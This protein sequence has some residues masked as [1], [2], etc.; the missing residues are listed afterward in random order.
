[1]I[2]LIQVGTKTR[3][4]TFLKH[5]E[6]VVSVS[7]K[8]TYSDVER[9]FGGMYEGFEVKI[10]RIKEIDL[11]PE[12]QKLPPPSAD[13]DEQRPISRLRNFNI[14]LTDTEKQTLETYNDKKREME[15]AARWLRQLIEE[16]YKKLP[17]ANID[18][19]HCMEIDIYYNDVICRDLPIRG[20]IFTEAVMKGEE[21]PCVDTPPVTEDTTLQNTDLP[22][23]EATPTEPAEF[24]TE[25]EWENT[26]N[27]PDDVPF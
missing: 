7:E 6:K 4:Q 1:M 14:K 16:R 5:H 20:D 13:E 26:G 17:Y 18:Y 27:K 25:W 12:L 19:Q 3:K 9:F 8:Y 24:T 11:S 23:A 10:E 15:N 21:I 2:Y 22:L